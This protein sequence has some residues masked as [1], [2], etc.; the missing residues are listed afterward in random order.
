MPVDV[1]LLESIA[2]LALFADLDQDEL[3]KMLPGLEEVSYSEGHWILRRGDEDVGLHVIV[4]GE[5]GVV[6][7]DEELAV[8]SKGSFFGE[9]SAL[10]REPTVADIV[11]RTNVR[12]LFVPDAEVESFLLSSPRV[13]FRMLQTEARR[14]RT[15]DERHI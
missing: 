12:C 8:L 15:T 6:L 1:G 5:V 13:M 10:L 2:R 11:A 4:D 9:I 7:E 14:V 3:E